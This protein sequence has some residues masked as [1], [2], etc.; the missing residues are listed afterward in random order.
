MLLYLSFVTLATLI[1]WSEIDVAD[2]ILKVVF[3]G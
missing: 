3:V 2:S 1:S